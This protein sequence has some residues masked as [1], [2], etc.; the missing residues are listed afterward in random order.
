MNTL[1]EWQA[2]QA[3]IAPRLTEFF[4]MK[5]AI[6]QSSSI[7]TR[8]I[9]TNP[10]I[11]GCSFFLSFFLSTANKFSSLRVSWLRQSSNRNV[12]CL[13][14][15]IFQNKPKLACCWVHGW[16]TILRFPWRSFHGSV[17]CVGNTNYKWNNHD[18][19]WTRFHWTFTI[20]A[21]IWRPKTLKN[22]LHRAL[23]LNV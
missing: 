16:D 6:R 10:R 21:F 2:T 17:G 8:C 12:A 7:N 18:F 4:F 23:L 14:N 3:T 19:V 15:C 20:L 5:K 1:F 22:N 9:Q 11:I 13:E